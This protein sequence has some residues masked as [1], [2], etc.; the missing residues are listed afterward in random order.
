MTK[1]FDGD[2]RKG[3]LIDSVS[4]T[5]GTNTDCSFIKAEKGLAIKNNSASGSIVNWGDLSSWDLGTGD[6]TIVSAFKYRKSTGAAAHVFGKRGGE[7]SW[8]RHYINSSHVIHLEMGGA[9]D[10]LTGPALIVGQTYLVI[11]SRKDGDLFL[12]INNIDSGNTGTNTSTIDNTGNVSIA[13]WSGNYSYLNTYYGRLYDTALTSQERNDL[14]KEFLNSYG[15]TEQKRNFTYPKPTDLSSEVDS[16]ITETAG[17]AGCEDVEN[18]DNFSTPVGFTWE[19][20]VN[21]GRFISNI[22]TTLVVKDGSGSGIIESGKKYRYVIQIDSISK[23]SIRLRYNGADKEVLSSVGTHVM[24]FVATA[25]SFGFKRQCD[26]DLVIR[27]ISLTELTGLVAA[28][29]MVPSNGTLVDI[30]REGNNGTI[31]GALSTKDGMAFDGV[32]DYVDLVI[33]HFYN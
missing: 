14:Y 18:S 27:T 16:V 30:S 24:E 31:S 1:V 28:Y 25:T 8:L 32:D 23:G 20:N 4:K 3:T 22:S 19:Q 26:T 9:G 2:G 17:D 29:S 7:A 5:K 33:P 13:D 12:Y 6:Y 11:G 10:N 21:G 15:T